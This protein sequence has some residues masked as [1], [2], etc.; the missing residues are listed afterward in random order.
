MKITKNII[1]N[2]YASASSLETLIAIAVVFVI[3][4]FFL[5]TVD[6]SFTSYQTQQPQ[7]TDT[8]LGT[9]DNLIKDEGSNVYG[10]RSWED[11]KDPNEMKDELSVLGLAKESDIISDITINSD[12]NISFG[13]LDLSELPGIFGFNIEEGGFDVI[14]GFLEEAQTCFLEDTRVLMA[15]GSYKDI[16]DVCVGDRVQSYDFDSGMIK[17]GVVCDVFHHS[18]SE[19][20]DYYLVFN[21]D[22]C[23]TPNHPLW[24]NGCWM[25]AEDV[26]VGD[27]L[28]G[29]VVSSIDL[30]FER[31]PTFNFEVEGYHNY[32]VLLDENPVLVHNKD[33]PPIDFNPDGGDDENDSCFLKGTKIVMAD[34]TLKNIED[35]KPGDYV[36]TYDGIR[37]SPSRVNKTF[38]HKPDEMGNYYLNI[39]NEIFVTPNHPLYK[40]GGWI[41]VGDLKIGDKIGVDPKNPYLIK[42]IEKIFEKVPTF[43]FEVENYHNYLVSLENED[44]LAHNDFSE[45]NVGDLIFPFGPGDDDGGKVYGAYFLLPLS[46]NFEFMSGSKG[47]TILGTA[48]PIENS[49]KNFLSILTQNDFDLY[50]Y[51][52]VDMEKIEALDSLYKLSGDVGYNKI[53]ESLG[54]DSEYYEISLIIED[55]YGEHILSIQP[56][57]VPSNLKSTVSRNIIISY[58]NDDDGDT[59][60]KLGKLTLSLYY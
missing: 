40:D 25:D 38:H 12:G 28:S 31:A 26:C 51:G 48:S 37:Y 58:V 11:N 29:V 49:N 15:D 6:D 36:K 52:I 42:S 59:Y 35:I 8:T 19:M 23:V 27:D 30:V 50:Y 3:I 34:E 33:T 60:Y 46:S 24:N 10:S 16:E 41:E 5:I 9:V 2:K 17:P 1:K 4:S 45:T 53:I 47:F 22:L 56:N 44:I 43:N 14:G 20:M 32:Y 54:L 18:D 39:N 13:F 7:A 21:D 57:A 55:I